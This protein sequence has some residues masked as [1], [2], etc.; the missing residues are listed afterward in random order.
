MRLEI[1]E[2]LEAVATAVLRLARRRA[3]ARDLAGARRSAIGAA[4]RLAVELDARRVARRRD[5]RR[6]QLAPRLGCD[7]VAAPWR[8]ER[9]DY[10]KRTIG[11]ARERRSHVRLDDAHRRT[12][13]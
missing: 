4:N 10:A 9:G 3:K 12:A 6:G 2:R 11:H 5:A 8:R 1:V 7:S 13:R